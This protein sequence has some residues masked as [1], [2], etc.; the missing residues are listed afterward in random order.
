LLLAAI[1]TVIWAMV[2][3]GLHLDGLADSADAWLGGFGDPAKTQRILKDPLVGAAG[4]IALVGV[5]LLKFA[6]L[7]AVLE[8]AAWWLILIAPVIGRILILLLFLSTPYVRAE[9]LASAVTAHLPRTTAIWIVTGGL[10]LGFTVSGSGLL[11]VLLG[12]WLLRRL[13]LQRL[14]GC[15]GD[16]A[17]ATVEIGEM[18]W[19][20]GCVIGNN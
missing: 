13:M 16:T 11:A 6:A 7:V 19:L 8:H 12:F 14:Q 4:V 1:L 2:T 15:T 10:L 5:L 17:G 18:L 9:G 20:V 3:G